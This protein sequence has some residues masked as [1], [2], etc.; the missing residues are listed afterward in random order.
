M[1]Q[2]SSGSADI[3]IAARPD[4][5]SEKMEFK[6][7][8]KTPLVFISDKNFEHITLEDSPFILP[9]HGLSRERVDRWFTLK[10][11]NPPDLRGNIR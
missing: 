11:N 7:V 10:K 9:A 2:I 8:T 3:G 1:K 4:V 6:T 5:L